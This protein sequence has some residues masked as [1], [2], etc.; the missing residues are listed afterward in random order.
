MIKKIKIYIQI[1]LFQINYTWTCKE[2]LF[3]KFLIKY[4]GG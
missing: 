4:I 2:I 3:L 1:I